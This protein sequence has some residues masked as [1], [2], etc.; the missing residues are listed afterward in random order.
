MNVII[1]ATIRTIVDNGLWFVVCSAVTSTCK[2]D[3][4]SG[5]CIEE[6][7][8]LNLAHSEHSINVGSQFN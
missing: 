7:N 3:G 2:V 5:R 4:R 1:S 6:W 8:R